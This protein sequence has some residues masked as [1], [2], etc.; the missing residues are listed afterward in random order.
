MGG[1]CRIITV[2]IHTLKQ[3][4]QYPPEMP[5]VFSPIITPHGVIWCA[6]YSQMF[7]PYFSQVFATRGGTPRGLLGKQE[8]VRVRF[9]KGSFSTAVSLLCPEIVYKHQKLML[10]WGCISYLHETHNRANMHIHLIN[11]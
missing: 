6:S 4:W 1:G 7:Y 2:F 10:G 3:E 5:C 11:L 8:L 9:N